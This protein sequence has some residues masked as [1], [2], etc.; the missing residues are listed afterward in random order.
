MKITHMHSKVKV[1]MARW[2]ARRMETRT[3]RLRRALRDHQRAESSRIRAA[4]RRARGLRLYASWSCDEKHAMNYK[5]VVPLHPP[6]QKI[7]A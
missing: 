3:R 4:D 6:S 2:L 1:L 5:T 7:A